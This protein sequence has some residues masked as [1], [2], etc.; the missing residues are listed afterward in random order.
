MSLNYKK[1]MTQSTL[2]NLHPNEYSEDLHYYSFT[3]NLDS[4]VRIFN[5]L[6]DLP[7]KVC[8]QNKTEDLELIV[9]KMITGINISDTLTKHI[10][11]RFQTQRRKL[12]FEEMFF[13]T[14]NMETCFS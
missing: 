13:L 4:C 11:C 5:N 8:G 6:N 1:C 12:H 3:I 9:F 7:N 2:I 10:F 14:K